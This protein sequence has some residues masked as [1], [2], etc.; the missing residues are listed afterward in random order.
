MNWYRMD[1]KEV[2]A[3]LGTSEEGLTEGRA[4]ELLDKHGPNKLAEEERISRFRI[5]L[6]QFTSPLI[7]ILL[8][9]AVVTVFLQ[10]YVDAGVILAV[11]ILNAVIGYTQEFKAEESVRA[12]KRLVVP[13]ARVVREGREKEVSSAELVPGDVV[14]L[15]SGAR[16]PADLR[17]L[18]RIELRVDEATLTGESLPVEKGVAP[19]AEENLIPADQTNLAFMG[20][21][22]VNG[23]ARG[24]VVATGDATVLGGIAGEVREIGPVRAPIQEKI[25]RFARAIGIIVLAAAAVLLVIGLIVGESLK[26]MFMTAV[27]AA[28]ATIPEGLPIVVTIAMAVGVARMARHNAIIRSGST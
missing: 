4:K 8:I 23:R 11:V 27:A 17:L 13:K 6:H 21:A 9:A 10:E 24:V 19:L 26:D 28:V 5:L 7:Y 2:L 1:A 20:T 12:L 25:D 15:A 14:L 22:V 16:V 3:A 18:H